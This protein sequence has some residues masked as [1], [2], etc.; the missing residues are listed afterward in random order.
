VEGDLVGE[1]VTAQQAFA[2]SLE[3]GLLTT[4]AQFRQMF[5]VLPAAAYMCDADGLITYFNRHAADLWGREPVLN[6]PV[7]RFCG[8]FRL[9]APNGDPI[10]HEECWMALSLRHFKEFNG[11]EILIERPDGELRTVLAHANPIR[12]EDGSLVGAVNVLIDISERNR[13]LQALEESRHE[14]ERRVQ[15]RTEE[16]EALN[17]ELESFNYSVSHDLR[18]PLRG[19]DGFSRVLE[20][21]YASSLDD[22]GLAYLK[23]I[24]SGAR[25][26]SKLIDALLGFSSIVRGGLEKAEVNLSRL[27]TTAMEWLAARDAGRRLRLEVAPDIVAFGD[28]R[29]L[30]IALENILD[31]AWKFSSEREEAVIEVGV[32]SEGGERV[33]FVRDNGTGFDMQYADRMF[34]PFQRLHPDDRFQGTGIGLA[35]VQRIIRRH[36]GRIWAESEPGH[37]ATFCFTL[38]SDRLA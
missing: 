25:R 6:D 3:S 32:R 18:A 5:D 37:G 22:T 28:E 33:F 27:A 34:V 38:P 26:M 7:D 13:A 15:E 19:I 36:G 8:S 24:R 2:L 1:Q 20:E 29:L 14:L 30:M 4:E 10:P 16:L 23:R 12:N 21:E 9:F 17:R 35:T 31:N 11:Q